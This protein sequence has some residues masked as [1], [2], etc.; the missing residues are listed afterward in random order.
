MFTTLPHLNSCAV[1]TFLF[2][3]FRLS[4][5]RSFRALPLP[6]PLTLLIVLKTFLHEQGK[7]N[8]NGKCKNK[9][10]KNWEKK[11]NK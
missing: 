5:W 4:E 6:T 2:F 9:T 7:L 8:L 3:C 10:R 1:E 11:E